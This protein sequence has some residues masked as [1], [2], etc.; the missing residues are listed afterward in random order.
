MAYLTQA[1][2][3]VLADKPWLTES[4][5]LPY[6][7]QVTTAPCVAMDLMTGPYSLRAQV[8]AQVVHTPEL[9]GTFVTDEGLEP[10]IDL[11]SVHHLYK[12]VNGRPLQRPGW[13]YDTAVQ[14]DGVVDVQAHMVAQVQAWV[15]EEAGG[16][17]EQDMVLDGARCWPTAVPLELFCDSTGL[18]AYPEALHPAV[19]DGVLQ[20]ACNSE[21][22]HRF[23]GIRIRQRAVA[24][25]GTG[26]DKRL[27]RL[28]L[29][30]AC[31]VRLARMRQRVSRRCRSIRQLGWRWTPSCPVLAQ[32]QERFPTGVRTYG[33]WCP[34]TAP[35]Y[36]ISTAISPSLSMLF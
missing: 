9:F 12:R 23:R 7:G 1:G 8:L 15:L 6:L 34:L 18:D 32:W 14:G 19:Q 11:A 21:I 10:A 24:A 33:G 5:Q 13:Y 25:A 26:R 4:R 36:F 30:G 35:A 20:Y 28:T 17:V 22:R 16:E 31:A 29:R 2:L 3:P 27:H